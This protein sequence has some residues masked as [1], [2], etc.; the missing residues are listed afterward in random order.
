MASCNNNIPK[1]LD[2]ITQLIPGA[3]EPVR[4]VG[5]VEVFQFSWQQYA[6]RDD[7]P[8]GHPIRSLPPAHFTREASS[9]YEL[10]PYSV[11]VLRGR[12]REP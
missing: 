3:Q 9:L 11:T 12:L 2:D 6:W 1:S 7:G 4:F 10:P 8:N 5:Q